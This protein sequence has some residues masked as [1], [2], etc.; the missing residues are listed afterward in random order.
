LPEIQTKGW[1]LIPTLSK[2]TKTL[3]WATEITNSKGDEYVNSVAIRLGREGYEHFTWVC[4]KSSYVPFGGDLGIMLKAFSFDPGYAYDDF[5]PGDK[6]ADYDA[7]D[8]AFG[9]NVVRGIFFVV[10]LKKFVAPIV[11]IITAIAYKFRAFF[12]RIKRYT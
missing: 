4:K 2:S 7:S 11:A 6:V 10:L 12:Q 1:L 3:Y 5:K 8:L 9:L